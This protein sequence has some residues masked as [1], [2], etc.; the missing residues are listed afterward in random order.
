MSVLDERPFSRQ[1]SYTIRFPKIK[2]KSEKSALST[3]CRQVVND[4]QIADNC[5]RLTEKRRELCRRHWSR[6]YWSRGDRI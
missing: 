2:P 4:W 3:N 5:S 6:N 1:S